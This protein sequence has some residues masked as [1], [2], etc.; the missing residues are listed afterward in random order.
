M[1]DLTKTSLSLVPDPKGA[2]GPTFRGRVSPLNNPATSEPYSIDAGGAVAPSNP[3]P[4]ETDVIYAR[5][6]AANTS[7]VAGLASSSGEYPGYVNVQAAGP[8]TLTTDQWDARTGQTGGLTPQAIYYLSAATPGALTTTPP[9]N[10]N[11]IT[12]VGFAMSATTMMIQIG[13]A[14]PASP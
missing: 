8:L 7:N 3:S 10:P 1:A 2:A 11:Y 12:P 6:N 4:T 13:A 9:S 5:A 14:V